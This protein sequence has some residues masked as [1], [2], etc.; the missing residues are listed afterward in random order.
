MDALPCGDHSSITANGQFG[1]RAS[2]V[3]QKCKKPGRVQMSHSERFDKSHDQKG[4][5]GERHP[6][7]PSLRRAGKAEGRKR[8][9]TTDYTD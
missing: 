7:A 6:P 9:L 3:A 5:G 1:N 2:A 8:S 4:L